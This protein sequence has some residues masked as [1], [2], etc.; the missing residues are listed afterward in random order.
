M[1]NLLTFILILLLGLVGGLYAIYAY[2]RIKRSGYTPPMAFILVSSCWGVS[3]LLVYLADNKALPLSDIPSND[4]V[5]ASFCL[6][7]LL[8]VCM[9]AVLPQRK[10]MRRSGERRSFPLRQ[11]GWMLIAIEIGLLIY[12]VNWSFSNL[13]LDTNDEIKAANVEYIKSSVE[14]IFSLFSF[15]MLCFYFDQL[16][17]KTIEKVRGEDSRYPMLYL[18]AFNQERLPFVMAPSNEYR[19]RNI[20][21][22]SS[23]TYDHAWISLTLEQYL[24]PEIE[25]EIGPFVALGSP[26]DYLPPEGA[27]RTYADD[28]DW[29]NYF[30]VLA[31]QARAIVMEVNKSDNLRWELQWIRNNGLQQKLFV[32]TKPK[33]PRKI[34]WLER[35]LHTVAERLT[36]EWDQPLSDSP[37]NWVAFSEDMQQLGYRFDFD[38]PGHGAI[39]SFNDFG[40]AVALAT[41]AVTPDD[42]IK[43]ILNWL[44]GEDYV[45][46]CTRI[47]CES[48]GSIALLPSSLQN[49]T[50]AICTNCRFSSGVDTEPK[51]KGLRERWMRFWGLGT[52]DFTLFV[53]WSIFSGFPTILILEFY[54]FRDCYDGY[55]PFVAF[56]LSLLVM[57]LPVWMVYLLPS[58]EQ[59]DQKPYKQENNCGSDKDDESS[60]EQYHKLV[61]ASVLVIGGLGLS[62]IYAGINLTESTWP[63][64]AVCAIAILMPWWIDTLPLFYRKEGKANSEKKDKDQS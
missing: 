14:V 2:Y 7:S 13:M 60:R 38:V 29:M 44:V 21:A 30:K 18:R 19:S 17:K 50:E 49:G 40:E 6:P 62:L 12:L 33:W 15:S 47:I 52:D 35:F 63:I 59:G 3:F 48:C 11:V 27:V 37:L 46:P 28:L 20:W 39:I 45:T 31:D 9:L 56:M 23:E 53:L 57:C 61:W 24:K 41:G 8:L 4:L 42:F 10:V 26:E 58:H 51:P 22:A 55:M 34:S 1:G 43:S 16:K 36:R 25:S 54:F 5:L 64:F 32:L